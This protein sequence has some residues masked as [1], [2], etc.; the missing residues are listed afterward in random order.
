MKFKKMIAGI[1]ILSTLLASTGIAF[2][3]AAEPGV[4]S[5]IITIPK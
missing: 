4:W 5:I 2:A 1:I 3:G